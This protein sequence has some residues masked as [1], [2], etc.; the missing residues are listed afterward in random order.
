MPAIL[1]KSTSTT[2]SST[3]KTFSP[4]I[5][6]GREPGFRTGACG[7]FEWAGWTFGSREVGLLI[8]DFSRRLFRRVQ[9]PQRDFSKNDFAAPVAI[10]FGPQFDQ[11]RVGSQDDVGFLDIPTNRGKC[12]DENVAAIRPCF[13]RI[14]DPDRSARDRRARQVQGNVEPNRYR[15]RFSEIEF[16][17]RARSVS[18]CANDDRLDTQAMSRR[19]Q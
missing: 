15:Q 16:E 9:P 11:S 17:C 7:L 6:C 14:D 1:R 19:I 5:F 13:S 12:G 2:Q 4:A 8:L 18:S 3:P 10:D